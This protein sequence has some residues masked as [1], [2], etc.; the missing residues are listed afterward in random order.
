MFSSWAIAAAPIWPAATPTHCGTA[1]KPWPNFPTTRSSTPAIITGRPRFPLW[2]EKS[3]RTRIIS[4]VRRRSSF[5][6]VST[7][8][9]S[10]TVDRLLLFIPRRREGAD[11]LDCFGEALH[12][13]VDV[14]L[15]VT[16]AHT[17]AKGTLDF[18]QGKVQSVEH[19][20]GRSRARVACRPRRNCNSLYIQVHE[21]HFP[22]H[23]AKAHVQRVGNSQ[24]RVTVDFHFRNRGDD[25]LL[26]GVPQSC[27]ATT[28][29]LQAFPGQCA[30]DPEAQDPRRVFSTCP[31][32]PFVWA[33]VDQG[34][35]AGPRADVESAHPLRAIDLVGG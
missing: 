7:V 25:F 14:R 26:E 13:G 22:V 28:I 21:K 20:G 5:T 30:G 27:N 12:D 34:C 29:R 24:S 2:D 3:P 18:I 32:V 35:H 23:S 9:S 33:S 8:K 15:L 6:C 16:A 1:F 11:P 19:V 31:A 4:V 10:R 17:H